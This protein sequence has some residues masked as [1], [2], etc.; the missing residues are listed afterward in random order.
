MKNSFFCFVVVKVNEEEK[1]IAKLKRL[2]ANSK[3]V[4]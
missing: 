2:F 1:E 3:K 4:T